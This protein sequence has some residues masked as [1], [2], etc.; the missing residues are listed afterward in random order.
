MNILLS[1]MAY[2][3]HYRLFILRKPLVDL[4][5]AV[6]DLLRRTGEVSV[7]G[8]AFK[9]KDNAGLI[10]DPKVRNALVNLNP[11]S[12]GLMIRMHQTGAQFFPGDVWE[13]V[14]DSQTSELRKRSLVVIQPC[15]RDGDGFQVKLSDTGFEAARQVYNFLKESLSARE[16]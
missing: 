7:R 13:N 15:S 9:T 1:C 16:V 2:S 14:Y 10:I 4:L 11:T 5:K 8:V 3:C 6:I 12:V